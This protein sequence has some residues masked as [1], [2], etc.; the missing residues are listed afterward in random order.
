MKIARSGSVPDAYTLS[1][2][3]RRESP[4]DLPLVE[5]I[6][7]QRIDGKLARDERS[8]RCCDNSHRSKEREADHFVEQTRADVRVPLRL[9]RRHFAEIE[10]DDS[11]SRAASGAQESDRFVPRQSAG[12][13]RTRAGTESRIE[14]VDVPR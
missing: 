10:S 14:T 7:Q 2:D 1:I 8:T 4:R 9:A 5:S 6:W 3:K 11:F 13:G 12:N